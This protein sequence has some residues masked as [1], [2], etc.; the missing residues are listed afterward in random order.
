MLPADLAMHRQKQGR[1][2]DADTIKDARGQYGVACSWHSAGN[3]SACTKTAR[4]SE[5]EVLQ[6]DGQKLQDKPSVRSSIATGGIPAAAAATYSLCSVSARAW[7]LCTRPAFGTASS[8][9]H[10]CASTPRMAPSALEHGVCLQRRPMGQAN[11]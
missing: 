2:I 5:A 6:P 10:G 9:Q 11:S 3:L 1:Q 4:V 8:S 7:G